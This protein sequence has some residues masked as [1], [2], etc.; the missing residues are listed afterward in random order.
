M[1]DNI[2]KANRCDLSEILGVQKAAFTPIA[3]M[4]G[5][6]TLLPLTHTLSDIEADYEKKLILK[7]TLDGRIVGSVRA[8]LD[9]DGACWIYTLVVLPMFQSRGIGKA[10][11]ESVHDRFKECASYKL[12]T[13]KDISFIVNFYKKLGYAETHAETMDGVMMV[14]MER[15]NKFS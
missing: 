1:T 15:K 4:L 14:F 12:F 5:K 6:D 2:Q 13:G 10:L 7:Y 9:E 3:A 8:R 11:L